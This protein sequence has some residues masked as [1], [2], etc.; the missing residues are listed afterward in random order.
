MVHQKFP[1][2]DYKFR[3]PTL[4]WEQTVRSEE[5]NREIQGESEEPQPTE[6]IDDAVARKDCWSIQGDFIY[7]HQTEPRVQLYVPKEET[8]PIPLKYI[9]VTRSTHTQLD[10]MQEKRIDDFWNVDDNKSLSDFWTGFTKLTLLKEE[11]PQGY[12]WSAGRLTKVQTT[13]RP[14]HMWRE[15]WT[16]ISKASQ[17]RERQEWVNDQAK[18]ENARRM[19]EIYFIDPEDE[20]HQETIKTC[21][22]TVG[23]SDGS[24]PCR[25]RRKTQTSRARRK[26]QQGQECP[27][28]FRRQSTLV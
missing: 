27:T 7:R 2:R 15:V 23:S 14:D 13:T 10:V 16:N 6:L 1:G 8:F 11:L 3:E 24:G 9:D 4:G 12:M 17:K 19:R 26:L 21:K 18:L 28:R 5:S 22:A 20:E 25:A